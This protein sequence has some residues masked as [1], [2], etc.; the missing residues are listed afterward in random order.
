MPTLREIYEYSWFANA[1]Y[2]EWRNSDDSDS[3]VIDSIRAERFPENIVSLQI[4]SGSGLATKVFDPS[5]EAWR[6]AH[7]HPDDHS[8]YSATLF[9]NADQKILAIRGTSQPVLDL[10]ETDLKEIGYYGIAVNQLVS[11]YNHVRLLQEE[12]GVSGVPQLV[13]HVSDSPPAGMDYL[14]EP[15][16]ELFGER[17]H[18]FETEYVGVGLGGLDWD[19]K[20]SVTGHS[21][22]GH[23]AAAALRLFPTQFAEAVTFNAPGFDAPIGTLSLIPGLRW[24]DEF[25]GLFDRAGASPAPDFASL[26]ARIRNIESESSSPGDDKS[27][28]SASITGTPAAK[29][30]LL[31]TEVNSHSM[32]QM[33]DA[34]AV[35]SVAAALNPGLSLRDMGTFMASVSHTPGDTEEVFLERLAKLLLGEQLD[36]PRGSAA[37]IESLWIQP[38]PFQTR[39]PLHEL[40]IRLQEWGDTHPGAMLLPLVVKDPGTLLSEAAAAGVESQAIR[41]ALIHQNPF[42]VTGGDDLYA[43]YNANGELA[44]YD[45]ATGTGWLSPTYLEDRADLLA[46]SLALNTLDIGSGAIDSHRYRIYQTLAPDGALST[47]LIEQPRVLPATPPELV[48]FGGPSPDQLAGG[49]A[50]DHLY[51]G[52]GDDNLRGAA[53]H[54][55][56]EGG[57]GFDRYQVTHGSGFDTVFDRDGSGLIEYDGVAIKGGFNLGDGVFLDVDS[58][59]RFLLDDSNGGRSTLWINGTVRVEHFRQG[60]LGVVLAGDLLLPDEPE[61]LIEGTDSDDFDGNAT[62]AGTLRG[63]AFLEQIHGLDG[64]DR[65]RGLAGDDWLEGGVGNDVLD[66]GEDNDLL[67]A[68]RSADWL[69]IV[70]A[71]PIGESSERDWLAGGGGKDWLFGGP[72]ADGLVGGRDN[73][74]VWGGPGND[75]IFG[76][77]EQI[78]ES[79]DW[80]TPG[81]GQGLIAALGELNPA[82]AG[83]DI[84]LAGAGN[85]WAWGQGGDDLIAGGEG[86]DHLSGDL[87]DGGASLPGGLHGSD[88][89][90]G[91]PGN[92]GITGDGGA[93]TLIGGEGDDYLHGDFNSVL[94][95][96]GSLLLPPGYHGDDRLFGGP[97]NDVLVGGGGRDWLEGGLGMDRLYGDDD[98]SGLL[99]AYQGD[100]YLA[101]GEGADLLVGNGGRDRLRGDGGDDELWGGAAD[102]YLEGGE[103]DDYLAGDDPNDLEQFGNDWLVGGNGQD[104]L[105]GFSGDDHM[106]G[107]AGRDRIFGGI[108]DDWIAG[109]PG[110]DLLAGQAGVDRLVFHGGD[111]IDI[112]SEVDRQDL[113]VFPQLNLIDI[114]VVNDTQGNSYLELS[115]GGNDR[116]YL[117]GGLVTPV[118]RY[119][120]A[121]GAE[122]DLAGL[123][124]SALSEP[125]NYVLQSPGKLSGGNGADI[126]GGSP[127]SDWLRGQDGNDILAGGGGSDLLEGG[128]G[129]DRYRAG[130]G[131]AQDI[132]NEQDG[133]ASILELLPG[134]LVE[135]LEFSR[136][137]D[138]LC[139]RIG[140]AGDSLR[141]GEFFTS[142]QSWLITD[143]VG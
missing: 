91:G 54:D 78:P 66:G 93:D 143:T 107:G 41:Y 18:W 10:Y 82:A 123:L 12:E 45:A 63:S 39:V 81:D 112:I 9:A 6:I 7:Y 38:S 21:L 100:D 118:D 138:D 14:T 55:Y 67:F 62:G 92:D 111:G 106:V 127:D 129:I 60:D 108:G 20:V 101:G 136:S 68:T 44:S 71:E 109:G 4:P 29:E 70:H 128:P 11:L 30:I 27:F 37:G 137:A 53:G 115:Y 94:I 34:L 1:A 74:L 97:G 16:I 88:T 33:L 35:Q 32:D 80:L 85:D 73:D 28:V 96:D 117:E 61:G 65:L 72:G 47:S 142:D 86:D 40:A 26:E 79:N 64:N 132:I 69:Q 52:N 141:I 3:I 43:Q 46:M 77:S 126:L 42:A 140:G 48:I 120:D 131:T 58:G 116:A 50:D 76:D 114:G 98:T 130:R 87:V 2:V 17:Y 139:V 56:L 104:E 75:R 121:G 105:F 49:L 99:L 25:F 24:S 125:V 36:L 15:S 57:G 89:I 84:I 51:G 124:N 133:E 59:D 83:D 90:D 134:T 5:H 122:L 135:E 110:D 113:L 8:G 119:L 19:D 22:G 95:A 102:D 103:G 23:L 13:Y 31:T